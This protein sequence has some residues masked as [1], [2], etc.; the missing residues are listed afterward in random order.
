MAMNN[1]KLKCCKPLNFN[2]QQNKK[3]IWKDA[4]VLSKE[5]IQIIKKYLHIEPETYNMN[6]IMPKNMIPMR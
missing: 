5:N 6:M 2:L 1:H 3:H 4:I